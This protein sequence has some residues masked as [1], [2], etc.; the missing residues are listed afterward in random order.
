MRSALAAW[1]PAA[2]V[3]VTSSGSRLGRLLIPFLGRPAIKTGNV[4][5][6]RL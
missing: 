5:A 6:W 4:L 2:V 1:R 3:A